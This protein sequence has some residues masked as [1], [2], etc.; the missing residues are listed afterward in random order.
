M[1]YMRNYLEIRF[2]KSSNIICAVLI[3]PSLK[4]NV[5]NQVSDNIFWEQTFLK[6]IF[7]IYFLFVLYLKNC[8]FWFVTKLFEPA[9]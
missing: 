2:M 4:Y 5:I 8:L 7:I 1:Q 6:F 9:R 3:P